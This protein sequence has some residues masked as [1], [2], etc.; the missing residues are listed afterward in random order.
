M[1]VPKGYTDT[2]SGGTRTSSSSSLIKK[3][4]NLSSKE[5]STLQSSFTYNNKYARPST[6]KQPTNLKAGKAPA[7]TSSGGGGGG[8]S[9]RSGYSYRTPSYSS[10]GYTPRSGGVSPSGGVAPPVAWNPTGAASGYLQSAADMF[11]RD[12]TIQ[13]WDVATRLYGQEGAQQIFGQLAP[14]IRNSNA[15]FLAMQGQDGIQGTDAEWIN[16]NDALINQQMTPGQFFNST[17]AMRNIL[18]AAEG[19]PLRA[20]TTTGDAMQ[21]TQNV[22]KLI[23]AVLDTGYH[24]AMAEAIQM[25]LEN[26]ERNYLASSAKAAQVPFVEYLQATNPNLTRLLGV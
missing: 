25:E 4:K 13:L 7:A 20:Y 6:L 17:E 21:Q 11:S 12:P 1:A 22:G 16:W 5:R 9:N 26:Q 24:G 14:T 10:S 23:G 19:S 18:N 8:G 15:L 3:L 2:G